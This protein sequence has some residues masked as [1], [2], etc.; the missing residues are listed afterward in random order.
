[1]IVFYNRDILHACV[2]KRN[3][4]FLFFLMGIYGEGLMGCH[5][6]VDQI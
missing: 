1:M 3:E 6:G 4:V 2:S 5:P